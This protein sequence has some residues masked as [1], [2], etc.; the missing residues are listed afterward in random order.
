MTLTRI[1]A[2]RRYWEK[3]PPTHMLVAAY[4][5]YK[6]QEKGDLGELIDMFEGGSIK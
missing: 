5:G 6:P 3:H 1:A 2:Y 4:L